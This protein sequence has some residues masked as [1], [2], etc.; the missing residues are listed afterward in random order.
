MRYS[1][2]AT[3]IAS[4]R[5]TRAIRGY[6]LLHASGDPGMSG[7][8]RRGGGGGK[9]GAAEVQR[10]E[11]PALKT[12]DPA[13]P[14]PQAANEDSEA[15]HD[16][17]HCVIC[18]ETLDGGMHPPGVGAC[19]HTGT[20]GL[21]FFRLRK[22]MGDRSCCICKVELE[23]VYV[24]PNPAAARP[25]RTLNIWGDNAGPGMVFDDQTRMF[26]P[27]EFQRDVMQ[28]LQAHIC[29]APDCR[30]VAAAAVC[31]LPC[32]DQLLLTCG[33]LIESYPE[34]GK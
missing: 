22:I 2:H 9:K 8:G 26:V 13:P 33:G 34:K 20:C 4:S 31:L 14:P 7:R 12:D 11:P 24:F 25:Y 1:F 30:C 29:Q 3:N 23:N 32:G 27:K 16:Q 28:G 18:T 5:L 21:C 17:D 10:P 19:E 15:H 6:F